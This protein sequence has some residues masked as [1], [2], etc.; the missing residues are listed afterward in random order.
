MEPVSLGHPCL[1]PSKKVGQPAQGSREQATPPE[2][3]P[4]L[5]PKEPG[6]PLNTG[7]R[8]VLQHVQALLVKRFHHAVRS[9]KDFLAQVPPHCS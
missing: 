6:S 1:G 5:E 2:G 3:H 7:V 8:L 9:H 4:S